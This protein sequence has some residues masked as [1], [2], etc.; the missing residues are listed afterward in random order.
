LLRVF[1]SFFFICPR[2]AKVVRYTWK[3]IPLIFLFAFSS[4][5]HV[6]SFEIHRRSSTAEKEKK[7]K[8]SNNVKKGTNLQKRNVPPLLRFIDKIALL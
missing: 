5:L 4:R 2:G 6:A 7:P 1:V 8:N 3:K